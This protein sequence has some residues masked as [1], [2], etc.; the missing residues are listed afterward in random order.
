MEPSVAIVSNFRY[1]LS[2]AQLRLSLF[3]YTPG[4][5]IQLF[6]I[7]MMHLF[8]MDIFLTALFKRLSSMVS[9]RTG[10]KGFTFKTL[11]SST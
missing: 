1:N 2:L 6:V 3:L 11:L 7:K 5:T 9:I 8:Q 10:D 4:L